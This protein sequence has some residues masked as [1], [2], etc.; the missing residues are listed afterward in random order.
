MPPFRMDRVGVRRNGAFRGKAFDFEDVAVS[1]EF[2]VAAP[3]GVGRILL[4]GNPF[5]EKE[6]P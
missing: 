6:F 4:M 5:G 1:E 3:I 2:R